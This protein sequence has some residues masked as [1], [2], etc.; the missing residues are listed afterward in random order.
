MKHEHTKWHILKATART[1][2]T[3]KLTDLQK[4]HMACLITRYTYYPATSEQNRWTLTVL[5]GSSDVQRSMIGVTRN[6]CHVFSLHSTCKTAMVNL[7]CLFFF[8]EDVVAKV[9]ICLALN[10]EHA[11]INQPTKRNVFS[12]IRRTHLSL[13]D[14]MLLLIRNINAKQAETAN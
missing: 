2:L 14:F 9:Q 8:G 12:F 1:Q 3:F 4:F 10:G 13:V 5:L 7:P 6:P 11:Y